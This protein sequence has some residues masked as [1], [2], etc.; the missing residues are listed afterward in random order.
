MRT[1]RTFAINLSKTTVD[2]TNEYTAGDEDFPSASVFDFADWRKEENHM[3]IL[4]E[5][6]NKNVM[7]D[8]DSFVMNGGFMIVLLVASSTEDKFNEAVSRI[9]GGDAMKKYKII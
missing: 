7:G 8:P 4:K 9:P 2:F 5:G 3:K 6:E 1:G